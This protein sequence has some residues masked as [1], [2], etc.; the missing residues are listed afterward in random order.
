MCNLFYRKNY[1]YEFQLNHI[2]LNNILEYV[3]N[4]YQKNYD[5]ITIVIKYRNGIKNKK[6]DR[7]Y[8]VIGYGCMVYLSGSE[9]SHKNT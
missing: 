1:K 2:Y 9:W 8:I 4:K 7:K 6:I 5:T 3:N